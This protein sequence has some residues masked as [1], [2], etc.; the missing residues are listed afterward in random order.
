MFKVNSTLQC[1]EGQ[2]GVI[3]K[4]RQASQ[5]ITVGKWKR[6]HQLGKEKEYK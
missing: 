6:G 2:K 4:L 3:I 5:I 1:E